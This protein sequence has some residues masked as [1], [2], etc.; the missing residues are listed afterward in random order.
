M[1]FYSLSP[2]ILSVILPFSVL[3]S[4]CSWRIASTLLL[5]AILSR[6]KRTVAAVLRTLGLSQDASFSKYHRILNGLDWSPKQGALILLRMLLMLVG[7]KRPVILLDETLERRKGKRIR[8]KGYY[9]DAVRSSKSQVVKTTGLKWLVMALSIRFEFAKR[10]FALPFFSILQASKK[11]SKTRGRRHKKTLDWSIQ[12]VMQLV[13]W[14]PK[15]PF[16]FVGDGGFACTKLAWK[17][18]GMGVALVTRLKMNARIYA[19]PEPSP[20][21]KRGRKPKRGKRLITF[22]EMTQR[23]DL[24]WEYAEITGYDGKNKRIKFL[25][26][27]SLWG[28]DKV[29]PIAIRWVLVVDPEGGMDPLPLMSTDVSQTAA[30]MIQLYI[31]RWGLEVT[32]QE[33]REHLGVETQRQWSDKAIART[34]PVLMALYSMICLIGS[35]IHEETPLVAERTAWYDK[36]CVSFSDLLKA[37]R[38]MLWRDNLFFRKGCKGASGEIQLE[39]SEAW[40]AWLLETLSR[41]A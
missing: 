1:T 38:G 30:K 23:D 36:E 27:T 6:G 26:N 9:R 3:F 14:F 40:K 21:G 39:E 29:S 12:M 4:S 31:D 16:I 5:G 15:V 41:A 32:F 8:A 7:N 34:T 10:A 11:S 35:R 19:L 20:K 2:H 22:K 25:T 37:V 17:C 33:T 18:F 24:C 13:R 28:V